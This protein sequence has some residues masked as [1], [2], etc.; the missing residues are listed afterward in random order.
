[1]MSNRHRDR[2]LA[3]AA[4]SDDR[5]EPRGREFSGQPQ[6]IVIASDHPRE[7]SR[8][9][10]VRK[11]WDIRVR[12]LDLVLMGPR[13]R[14]DE[15]IATAGHRGDVAR[16]I[17]AIA[18]RLPKARDVKA[19]TALFDGHVGPHLGQQISFA[20]DFV[21]LRHQGDQGV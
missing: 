6:D 11:T 7:T 18:E 12:R 9:V 21:G 8:Q 13:D 15:A 19:Q 20:D 16:A 5:D 14:R 4:G 2:C 1:M 10:C 3:H 17:F